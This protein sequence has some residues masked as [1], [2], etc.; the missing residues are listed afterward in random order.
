[1]KPRDSNLTFRIN[2]ENKAKLKK[3]AD[4]DNRTLSQFMAL[5]VEKVIAEAERK[6]AAR[7]TKG[8]GS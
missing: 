7:A 2:T 3:L 4:A 6:A 8:K 5:I 1:M